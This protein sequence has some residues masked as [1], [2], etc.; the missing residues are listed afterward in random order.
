MIDPS[1][2]PSSGIRPNEYSVRPRLLRHMVSQRIPCPF[3]LRPWPLQSG[4]VIWSKGA[5]LIV[6]GNFT[7]NHSPENGGVLFASEFSNFTLAGGHFQ[8]NEAQDGGILNAI[9]DS[10]VHVDGGVYSGNVASS[11]GG[12]FS[13]L[14][15]ARL[16]VREQEVF[17]WI[18]LCI[19]VY[20]SPSIIVQCSVVLGRLGSVGV[21]QKGQRLHRWCF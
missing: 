9:V 7:N 4:A 20:F 6:D 21:K 14:D 8:G 13:L 12:V 2:P 10:I 3:L 18:I 5:L 16:Q 1:R 17:A 19:V 11:K 15:G